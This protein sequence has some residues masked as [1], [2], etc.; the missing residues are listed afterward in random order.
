MNPSEGKKGGKPER[1]EKRE[2]VNLKGSSVTRKAWSSRGATEGE[3][4][5]D[6][7]G[8]TFP[9]TINLPIS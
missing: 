5:S 8:A 4:F 2:R 7:R 1:R 6:S 9:L 3:R